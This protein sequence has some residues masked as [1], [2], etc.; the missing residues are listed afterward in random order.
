MNKLSRRSLSRYA[1]QQIVAGEK[2]V[3]V[4]K[5]I[6]SVMLTDGGIANTHL[7]V[8]DI[9]YELEVSGHMS[10]AKLTTA[11]EVTHALQDEF[12]K[13]V[14]ESLG[15]SKVELETVQDPSLIGGYKLETAT[16]TWDMTIKKKLL[17]LKEAF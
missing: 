7:L 5:Q 13:T 17:Q 11:R 15:A 14:K 1:A 8:K 10:I 6:A 9:L 16:R 12:I 2:P 3:N 4:A